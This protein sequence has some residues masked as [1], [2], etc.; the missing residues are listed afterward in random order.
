VSKESICVKQLFDA[1]QTFVMFD[2]DL[3]ALLLNLMRWIRSI[4]WKLSKTTCLCIW[5]I[6]FY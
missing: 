3:I 6:L 1:E 2:A 5:K 4:D